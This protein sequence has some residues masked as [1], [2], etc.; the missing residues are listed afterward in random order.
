MDF[1]LNPVTSFTPG[2]TDGEFVGPALSF[3]RRCW[4]CSHPGTHPLR[5][6][7]TSCVDDKF[8]AG[9]PVQRFIRCPRLCGVVKKESGLGG[10]GACSARAVPPLLGAYL[11]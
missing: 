5:G 9:N 10:G 8:A 4:G 11:V 2:S 1:V 6:S 3:F 7:G